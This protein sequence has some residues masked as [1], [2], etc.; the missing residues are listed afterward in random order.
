MDS[1]ELS[2]WQ[3]WERYKAAQ[4]KDGQVIPSLAGGL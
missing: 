3:A 4:R 1:A 2:D